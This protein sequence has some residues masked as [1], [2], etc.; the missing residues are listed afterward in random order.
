MR[1]S[2]SSEEPPWD[3]VP[4]CAFLILIP[5][6]S[7]RARDDDAE[8]PAAKRQRRGGADGAGGA[9]GAAPAGT[10]QEKERRYF[11]FL[12]EDLIGDALSFLGVR[13][14]E[15]ARYAKNLCAFSTCFIIN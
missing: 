2:L 5:M 12:S 4:K 11:D 8:P 3:N 13:D 1:E 10:G 7:N 6:N 14:L 15:A 9:G